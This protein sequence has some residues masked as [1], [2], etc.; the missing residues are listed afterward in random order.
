MGGSSEG[1]PRM[2]EQCEVLEWRDYLAMVE[3][4]G[5]EITA[6]EERGRSTVVSRGWAFVLMLQR[7]GV[8]LHVLEEGGDLT[9]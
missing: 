3:T 5:V 1:H 2:K 9:L 8:I 7:V 4:Q 6:L